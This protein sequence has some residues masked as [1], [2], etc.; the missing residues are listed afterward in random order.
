MGLLGGA[1]AANYRATGQPQAK[2]T[3]TEDLYVMRYRTAQRRSSLQAGHNF[4]VETLA[5]FPGRGCLEPQIHEKLKAFFSGRGVRVEWFDIHESKAVG[6][7]SSL[8]QELEAEEAEA[9]EAA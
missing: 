6:I 5:I 1:Q 8:I 9:A 4:Y 2:C 3:Q 7:V